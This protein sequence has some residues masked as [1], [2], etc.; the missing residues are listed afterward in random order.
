MSQLLRVYFF[1]TKRTVSLDKQASALHTGESGGVSGGSWT[2]YPTPKSMHVHPVF[3]I[4]HS[5]C[6]KYP[7]EKKKILKKNGG[8]FMPGCFQGWL[9]GGSPGMPVFEMFL[10]PNG[11]RHM[12]IEDGAL[13]LHSWTPQ[14]SMVSLEALRESPGLQQGWTSL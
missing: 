10:C 6:A 2:P 8:R 5:L 3:R 14:S 1:G 11:P 13:V 9:S 12:A 7:M 4:S